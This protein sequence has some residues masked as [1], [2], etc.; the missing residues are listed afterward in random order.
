M[1]SA[2]RSRPVRR[3]ASFLLVL[4]LVLPLLIVLEVILGE[5]PL[6]TGVELL[7]RFH[8][9]IPQ[10]LQLREIAARGVVIAR[11]HLVA[12]GQPQRPRAVALRLRRH[13]ER[14]VCL[15]VRRRFGTVELEARRGEPGF[16]RSL[17]LAR[18]DWPAPPRPPPPHSPPASLRRPQ[19][20]TPQH[21]PP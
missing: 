8:Q 17:E 12:D 13:H 21:P 20:T 16:G 9:H 2:P 5:H 14:V 15:L 7:L 10:A 1:D 19:H 11:L 18:G 4:L 3:L 6:E